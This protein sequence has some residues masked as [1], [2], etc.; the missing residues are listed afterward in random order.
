MDETALAPIRSK[1][2]DTVS[3]LSHLGAT[4]SEG[5]TDH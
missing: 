1:L 3:V 5:E 4:Q 2:I